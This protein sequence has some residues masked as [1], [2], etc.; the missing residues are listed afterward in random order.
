[1]KYRC[2]SCGHQFEGELYTTQKCP[3]CGSEEID[4]VK[5]TFPMK[6]VYI[7]LGVIAAIVLV[8]LMF[9]CCGGRSNVKCAMGITPEAFTITITSDKEAVPNKTFIVR[10][11]DEEDGVVDSCYVSNGQAVFTRENMSRDSMTYTFE[12]FRI[13]NKDFVCKWTT[14]HVYLCVIEKA[15]CIMLAEEDI[16]FDKKSKT[17]TITVHVT[18][19]QAAQY[20]IYYYDAKTNDSTILCSPQQE[21]V[22]KN[23]KPIESRIYITAQGVNGM[24]AEPQDRE[25]N[26]PFDFSVEDIERIIRNFNAGKD[27][28]R[29]GDV[30]DS[31]FKF[32]SS[33]K[34]IKNDRGQLEQDFMMCELMEQKCSYNPKTKKIVF[35]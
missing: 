10:V 24:I 5:R 32:E 2:N 23:V 17:F 21:S 33:E 35:K 22:F 6:W 7:A 18:S 19:G 8:F 3:Q 14:E 28:Y 31:L 27:G 29:C 13:D 12:V 4:E 11:F 15:P 34:L 9:K 16:V 30:C 25:L 26:V 1:M 20:W